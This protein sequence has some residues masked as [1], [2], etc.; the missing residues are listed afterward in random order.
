[1]ES[2]SISRINHR[3]TVCRVCVALASTLP[4]F[5]LK[6][7]LLFWAWCCGVHYEAVMLDHGAGSDTEC[8][9]LSIFI[10]NASNLQ[11]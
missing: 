7:V 2:V 1:M 6:I 5:G 11:A 9:L 8:V 4:A 3:S 10:G